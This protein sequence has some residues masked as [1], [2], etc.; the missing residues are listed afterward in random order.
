MWLLLAIILNAQG[1]QHVQI[2]K[3]IHSEQEQ[4]FVDLALGELKRLNVDVE[5]F[6]RKHTKDDSD[7]IIKTEKKLLQEDKNVKDK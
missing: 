6:I 1:V 5:E 4:F 2:L 7:K 3:I